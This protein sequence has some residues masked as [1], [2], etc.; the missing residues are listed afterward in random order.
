MILFVVGSIY[1]PQIGLKPQY[2][3]LYA[4]GQ[5]FY[6][7]VLYSV[8]GGVLKKKE[9]SLTEEEIKRQPYLPNQIKLYVH[10][11]VANE[12]REVTFEEAQ[13]LKLSTADASPDGFRFDRGTK[14]YGMIGIFGTSA[15]YDIA[16]LKKGRANKRIDLNS[17]DQHYYYDTRFLGWILP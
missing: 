5:D 4:T 11:T 14:N 15:D 6:G 12:N 13:K 8:E 9:I 1:L 17:Y 7:N 3:F 10:D 16:Y 2:D